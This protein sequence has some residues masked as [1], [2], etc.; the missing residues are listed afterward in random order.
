MACNTP[1][2]SR[3]FLLISRPNRIIPALNPLTNAV[4]APVALILL[5]KSPKRKTE[6]I[7]GAIYA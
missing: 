3:L 7:G 2:V 6:A 4:N 5:Q 1:L